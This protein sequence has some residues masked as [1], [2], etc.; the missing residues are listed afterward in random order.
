MCTIQVKHD[1]P[2]Q[3]SILL[4]C[5]YIY[6]CWGLIFLIYRSIYSIWVVQQALF[7]YFI[8]PFLFLQSL[9]NFWRIMYRM[10][11]PLFQFLISFEIFLVILFYV[12]FYPRIILFFP[13]TIDFFSNCIIFYMIFF[14]SSWYISDIRV[15]IY[16]YI[17][18]YL[19]GSKISNPQWYNAI[20]KI[21]KFCL[22]S[23][24]LGLGYFFCNFILYCNI[25]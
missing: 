12:F 24:K 25:I 1:S 15:H 2:W 16:I 17:Y 21:Q 7:L 9:G 8:L 11:F 5:K 22:M 3:F 14:F 6:T 18:I 20:K 19:R 13:F 23:W 10:S 4:W